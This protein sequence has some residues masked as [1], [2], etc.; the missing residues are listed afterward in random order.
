MGIPAADSPVEGTWAAAGTAW[1][2]GCSLA[3]DRRSS[4][5]CRWA[6]GRRGRDRPWG[7]LESRRRRVVGRGR[8]RRLGVGR[9]GVGLRG[10]CRP[11]LICACWGWGLVWLGCCGCCG[12]E[13]LLVVVVWG[14]GSGCEVRDGFALG[15]VGGFCCVGDITGDVV[16]CENEVSQ[17]R[18]DRE[19][20]VLEHGRWQAAI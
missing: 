9:R 7:V 11:L 8:R 3:V 1:A 17:V 4:P 20:D 16:E 18:G 14:S 15:W 10:L 12:T 19:R 6:E 13:A 2:A 5:G